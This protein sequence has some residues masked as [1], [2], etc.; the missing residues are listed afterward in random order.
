MGFGVTSGLSKQ[1]NNSVSVAE[2]INS[3]GAIV[4][5]T[6]HGGKQEVQEEVYSDALTNEA[7][8]GQS[9]TSVVSNHNLIESATDYAR[10]SKTTI[11]ALSTTA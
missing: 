4:E 2:K 9:G 7:V 8:N 6:T 1:T 10:E 11:T 5:M 3:K